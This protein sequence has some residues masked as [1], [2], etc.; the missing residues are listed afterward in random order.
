MISMG[1]NGRLGNPN[2]VSIPTTACP[3]SSSTA[4]GLK[5]CTTQYMTSGIPPGFEVAAGNNADFVTFQNASLYYLSLVLVQNQFDFNKEKDCTRFGQ[6]D[7][8]ARNLEANVT[9]IGK[10]IVYHF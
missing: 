3:P 5:V 4:I 8:C 6:W 2:V 9:A 10:I 7:V 1:A